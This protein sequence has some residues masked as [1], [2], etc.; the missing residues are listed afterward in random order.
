MT[1]IVL[2]S[3]IAGLL[4]GVLVSHR[5]WPYFWLLLTVPFVSAFLVSL[6]F[7][8][9]TMFNLFTH[10][11]SRNVYPVYLQALGFTGLYVLGILFYGALPAMFGYLLIFV[12]R[13]GGLFERQ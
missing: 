10:P 7:Y 11:E 6:V 2:G 4:F 9:L 12:G 1:L 13:S 3:L 8:L 5:Q